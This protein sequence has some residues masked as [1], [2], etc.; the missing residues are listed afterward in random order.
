MS[1]VHREM[2]FYHEP[3]QVPKHL[4]PFEAE[5]ASKFI[6][7]IQDMRRQL[8]FE[9]RPPRTSI[10][11]REAWEETETIPSGH[12]ATRQLEVALPE[13]IWRPRAVF[14]DLA[15]RHMTRYLAMY[16]SDGSDGN[17]SSNSDMNV[18]TSYSSNDMDD[19]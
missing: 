6:Q 9:T 8:N 16:G 7:D 18:D 19:S 15:L 14:W 2:N 12:R 3:V 1:R 5:E 11:S 17:D 13:R 4:P 10:L